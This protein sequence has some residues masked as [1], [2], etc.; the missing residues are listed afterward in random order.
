[1]TEIDAAD[2]RILRRAGVVRGGSS[3]G[4]GGARADQ[5]HRQALHVP[6]VPSMY[7]VMDWEMTR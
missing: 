3:G 6:V 5:E 7:M 2:V 1:M 4:A